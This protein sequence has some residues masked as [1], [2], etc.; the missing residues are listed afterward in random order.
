MFHV[1]LAMC[2]ISHRRV[3]VVFFTA[4][5]PP[6]FKV[7]LGLRVGRAPLE[8]SGEPSRSAEGQ[9][10]DSIQGWESGWENAEKKTIGKR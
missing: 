1:K 3:Y 10:V 7:R 5:Q 4:Q 8:L 2:H 6:S 9:R